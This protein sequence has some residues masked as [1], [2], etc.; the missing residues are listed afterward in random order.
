MKHLQLMLSTGEEPAHYIGLENYID[1]LLMECKGRQCLEYWLLKNQQALLSSHTPQAAEY[2]EEYTLCNNTLPHSDSPDTE[3]CKACN[4]SGWKPKFSHTKFY[5]VSS[6]RILIS[7]FILFTLILCS[8]FFT[9]SYPKIPND[10]P[11]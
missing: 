9:Q 11:S 10:D 6:S 4:N 3:L 5:D 7:H 8:G 1:G 2:L